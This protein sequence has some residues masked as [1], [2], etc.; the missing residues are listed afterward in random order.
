MKRKQNL[1]TLKIEY[2]CENDFDW[3][4]DNYGKIL[5]FTYNRV[6]E[7]PKI[8]TKEL[9]LKQKEMKSKQMLIQ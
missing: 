6:I 3:V 7:N 8:S 9:T 2:I 1:I 5:R 4:I